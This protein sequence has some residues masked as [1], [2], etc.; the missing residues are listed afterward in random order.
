[1]NI[2]I[3][4]LKGI[5]KKWFSII[6]YIVLGLQVSFPSW[7]EEYHVAKMVVINNQERR[8]HLF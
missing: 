6:G 7:C 1:M 3:D 8:G 2:T 4:E 5:K